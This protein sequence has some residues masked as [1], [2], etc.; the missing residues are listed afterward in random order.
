M[1]SGSQPLFGLCKQSGT[2]AGMNI[3]LSE[4]HV[5]DSQ[6]ARESVNPSSSS[7]G[8]E[9]VELHDV[10]SNARPELP[11]GCCYSRELG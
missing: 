4:I 1:E 10:W 11:K 2:R 3:S 7:N 6:R 9:S 5:N 8:L